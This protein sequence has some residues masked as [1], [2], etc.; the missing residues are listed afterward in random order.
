VF[1]SLAN[2]D[3]RHMIFPVKRLADLGFS[4]MATAGTAD[5]LRRNGVNAE[6]VAKLWTGHEPNGSPAIV[7][8]ILAGDVALIV[9]TPSGTTSGGSP[10]NDGYEIRRAA[11]QANI[12]CITTVQGLAAA[13]Q[14]IEALLTGRIGVRSLQSWSAALR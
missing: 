8:R 11:I 10:R 4:I 14:G 9:N 12:A 13:V 6:V 3:K 5:V 1:V 7:S 2:R